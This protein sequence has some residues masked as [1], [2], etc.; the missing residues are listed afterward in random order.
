MNNKKINEVVHT[1]FYWATFSLDTLSINWLCYLMYPISLFSIASFFYSIV[2]L[3]PVF[4]LM[5]NCSAFCSDWLCNILSFFFFLIRQFFKKKCVCS[6][7]LSFDLALWLHM[8][9]IT[10]HHICLSRDITVSPALKIKYEIIL[11]AFLRLSSH[12]WVNRYQ[13]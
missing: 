1:T 8:Q 2:I 6:S 11:W 4:F 7:F 5:S 9:Y 12:E 3:N 10:Y 13:L